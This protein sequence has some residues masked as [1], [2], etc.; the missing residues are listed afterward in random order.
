MNKQAKL[1]NKYVDSTKSQIF[2]LSPEVIVIQTIKTGLS[3]AEN[4]FTPSHYK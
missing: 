1:E 4:D 2:A 3:E